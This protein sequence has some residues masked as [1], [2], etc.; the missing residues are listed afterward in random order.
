MLGHRLDVEST[1]GQGSAFSVLV[2]LAEARSDK[3]GDAS[4]PP[5]PGVTGTQS[6][7]VIDND[8]A[9]L[10][11]M[12]ALLRNWG[13]QVATATGPHED[14]AHEA[15]ARGVEL[16]IAD[17]HLD[18][19]LRGDEA[20]AMVRKAAG[21]DIPALIITADRS[22]EVKA[23]LAQARVP[24]LNKPVKPAQLRALMRN[25]LGNG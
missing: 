9:I 13:H 11:G 5:R 12:A 16:I 1:L 18:D 24:M 25:M 20:I 10:A 22:D 8:P 21:R 15:I 2:P 3:S 23:T 4:R 7:L 6:L 19:A 17:Y 14:E